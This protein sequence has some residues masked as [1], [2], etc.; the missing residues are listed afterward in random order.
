MR[1]LIAL[2]L[3]SLLGVAACGPLPWDD[4]VM[5][6]NCGSS[7][8]PSGCTCETRWGSHFE[9]DWEGSE[10]QCCYKDTPACN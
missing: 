10:Q 7:Q 6:T 2:V 5:A 9:C 4:C 3:T 8:T 1:L